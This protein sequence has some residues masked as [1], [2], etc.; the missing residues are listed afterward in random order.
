MNFSRLEDIRKKLN[1]DFNRY[2]SAVVRD[3]KNNILDKTPLQR[4]LRMPP[5]DMSTFRSI[6]FFYKDPAL[7]IDRVFLMGREFS[8]ILME[9]L[10]FGVI[11]LGSG[12]AFIA[13]FVT[14]VWSTG[15]GMLRGMLGEANIAKKTLVDKRFLI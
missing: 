4:F 11:D 10:V 1:D 13:A 7:S 9:I 2:I 14:F 12:N 8:L 3:A 15:L 5:T 6:P